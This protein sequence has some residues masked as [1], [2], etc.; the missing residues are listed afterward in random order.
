M[1]DGKIV[2]VLCRQLILPKNNDAS[3]QWLIGSPFFPQFTI[4]S[5]L[6]CLHHS[7]SDPLSPDFI[8]EADDLRSL[9]I[10][11]FHVIGALINSEKGDS[12]QN[13]KHAINAACKLRE[14]LYNGDDLRN[15]DGV[16]RSNGFEVNYSDTCLYSKKHALG[17]LFFVFMLM[18]C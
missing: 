4:V 2:R 16:L 17:V 18:T 13:A 10:K 11:G 14:L 15:F 6:R 5:T 1:D 12:V 9:I 7:Q 8:K 3:L